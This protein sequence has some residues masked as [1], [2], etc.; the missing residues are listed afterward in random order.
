MDRKTG[1]SKQPTQASRHDA[2][3]FDRP[4]IHCI[5]GKNE[6]VHSSVKRQMVEGMVWTGS[7]NPWIGG[8]LYGLANVVAG[9]WICDQYLGIEV[10]ADQVNSVLY[11]AQEMGAVT[12]EWFQARALLVA[13]SLAHHVCIEALL[14]LNT[15]LAA[16]PVFHVAELVVV[17]FAVLV[18]VYM[19]AARPCC[20]GKCCWVVVS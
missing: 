10:V 7:E 14:G 16:V 12:L 19:L 1:S 2:R 4:S 17:P 15:R 18:A 8:V 13:S 9:H 6:G 11:H 3:H 20:L 5:S